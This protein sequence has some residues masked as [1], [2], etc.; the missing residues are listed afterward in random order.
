MPT[1]DEIYG[2]SALRNGEP[3]IT[4]ESL[5]HLRTIIKPHWNVFEW[6]SGGSTAFWSRNCKSVIS[7][8][9]NSEWIQRTADIMNRLNCPH[10]YAIIYVRGNGI[11]HTKAF[12]E[13]ADA[14]L[15]YPD[16]SFDLVFVDGEASCRG[17]CITNALPKLKS[18]GCLLVDNSNWLNESPQ[19]TT[20]RLD[21]I[22]KGLK[23]IGQPGT[24]DWQT[25][26]FTKE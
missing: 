25:S 10:N 6:G 15:E 23:W 7:I 22:E 17:W 3:W 2:R 8:E 1:D 9:H 21:F 13:Y 4:P 19:N 20:D 11:D 26:I 24:F 16:D 12:R 18:G 14:I 5:K